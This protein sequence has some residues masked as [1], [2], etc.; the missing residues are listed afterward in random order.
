MPGGTRRVEEREY[1]PLV[2]PAAAL[3]LSDE[4]REWDEA[5][6]AWHRAREFRRR[7]E[8]VLVRRG[9]YWGQWQV[10]VVVDRLIRESGD[11]VS[12]REASR[13]TRLAKGWVSELVREL[14]LRGLLDVRPDAWGV[15]DRIWVTQQ[16]Q[17]LIVK[18]RAEL[19]EVVGAFAAIG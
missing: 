6:K 11:A 10:L 12:Q 7:A 18:L 17:E 9:V 4:E 8:R 14:S 19:A 1:E 16:G 3:V 5:I 13:R 2:F 15:F